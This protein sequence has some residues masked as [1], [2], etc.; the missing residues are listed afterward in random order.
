MRKLYTI[1]FALTVLLSASVSVNAMEYKEVSRQN[2]VYAFADWTETNSD[3]TTYTYLSVD[4]TDD[5]THIYVSTYTYNSETGYS[6]EKWGSVDTQ[7]NIFSIDKKLNSAS[8]SQ[9]E[10]PV[11]EWYYDETEDCYMSKEA[12]TLTVKADWTGVGDLSKGSFKYTSKEGDSVFRS[13]ENSL[14]R[15]ASVTGSVN[16]SDLGSQYYAGMVSFKSASMS[17]Q[18]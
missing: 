6:S 13:T 5:W 11:E 1:I 8:L 16:G 3:V 15:E 10:I 18:K 12:G 2:G 9:V 4:E 7:D 17:M 14:S